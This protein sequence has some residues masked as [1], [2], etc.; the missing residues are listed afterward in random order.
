MFKLVKTCNDSEH[1][2]FVTTCDIYIFSLIFQLLLIEPPPEEQK[3]FSL[4]EKSKK[5]RKRVHY[6]KFTKGRF[7]LLAS[8]REQR[9]K[10]QHANCAVF[11][12]LILNAQYSDYL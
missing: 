3:G 12:F 8:D 11:S 10:R 9:V 7:Y 4:E 2:K 5:S 1:L 6:V